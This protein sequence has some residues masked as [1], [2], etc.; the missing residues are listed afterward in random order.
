MLTS[1]RPPCTSLEQV[2]AQCI[3]QVLD[4]PRVFAGDDFVALGGDPAAARAVSARLGEALGVPG[5]G[6][7]VIIE[8]R[9]VQRI[10]RRLSGCEARLEAF[11]ALWLAGG[12]MSE[13]ELAAH[14]HGGGC[15]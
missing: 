14:L 9:T 1:E 4:R 5:P 12:D 10:A 13:A 2:L 15:A 6:V 11:A 3:S 8:E 7:D